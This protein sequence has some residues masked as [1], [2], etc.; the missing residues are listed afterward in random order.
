MARVVIDVWGKAMGKRVAMRVYMRGDATVEDLKAR[1]KKRFG[2]DTAFFRLKYAVLY[3]CLPY[4]N[5]GAERTLESVTKEDGYVRL[6][7]LT[8]SRGEAAQAQ[9][10]A[11]VGRPQDVNCDTCLRVLTCVELEMGREM[12]RCPRCGATPVCDVCWERHWSAMS[13][14]RNCPGRRGG[15]DGPRG[16]PRGSWWTGR[17]TSGRPRTLL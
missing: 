8:S 3:G 12:R 11:M 15:G 13:W 17:R 5:A 9:A 14:S 7:V 6:R 10:R 1:V 2:V 4:E 16:R